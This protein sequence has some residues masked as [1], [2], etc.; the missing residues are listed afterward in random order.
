VIGAINVIAIRNCRG[1]WVTQYD[2]DKETLELQD[3]N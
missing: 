2:T 1:L 3:S